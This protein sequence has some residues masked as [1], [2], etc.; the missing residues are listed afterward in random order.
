MKPGTI[1]PS[2]MTMKIRI[3]LFFLI[4]AAFL[5]TASNLQA[6]PAAL[7]ERPRIGLVLSGGGARGLAHVGVI[8]VLEE[9]K[10][11]IS[12]I[13]GTSMGAIVGGIY[14]SGMSPAELEK[15]ITSMQWNEAFK[16]KPDASEMTFRRKRDAADFLIDLDLGFKDGEFTMPRGVLQGQ[17]LNLILKSMLI[18]TE[19][20]DDF[21]RLNIPFRAVAADIET[22]DAVILEKGSW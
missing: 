3:L 4:I 17:N 22:G 7:D 16:D 5:F 10:I 9:M 21:N 8:Q 18:H 14:A 15:F 1:H 13:A 20:I 11:P 12:C 6:G 19:G 2:V